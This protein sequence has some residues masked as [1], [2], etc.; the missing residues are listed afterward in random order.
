MT[1]NVTSN[2]VYEAQINW[3]TKISGQYWYEYDAIELVNGSTV[4]VHTC[5]STGTIKVGHVGI[6]QLLPVY[7]STS[8]A[9]CDLLQ[10]STSD[11]KFAIYDNQI[12]TNNGVLIPEIEGQPVLYISSGIGAVVKQ[13][14][15]NA[16]DRGRYEVLVSSQDLAFEKGCYWIEY[17]A[18]DV[19]INKTHYCTSTGTIRDEEP[20]T[21]PQKRTTFDENN[22]PASG[23]ELVWVS[24]QVHGYRINYDVYIDTRLIYSGTNTV[25]NTGALIGGKT[26]KWYVEA[27]LPGSTTKVKSDDFSFIVIGNMSAHNYPNPFSPYGRLLDKINAPTAITFWMRSSGWADVKI[28]SEYGDLCWS[29]TWQ[30]ANNPQ[31]M[32]YNGY[33]DQGNEMYNGTY[34]VAITKHYDDGSTDSET[35]RMMIVK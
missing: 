28:Y 14:S 10:T 31:R 18:Y 19:S 23:V 11:V 9:V 1:R 7:C 17:D 4:A 2:R 26:Y 13:Y 15:M 16:Q 3:T 35:F 33:D 24:T 30:Y 21:K 34:V 12:I 25:C 5:T 8:D 20:L 6:N 27:Y 22:A 32:P 29:G